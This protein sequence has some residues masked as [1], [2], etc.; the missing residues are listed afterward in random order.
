MQCQPNQTNAC[1]KVQ[2]TAVQLTRTSQHA[3]I[4]MN[5]CQQA[6]DTATGSHLQQ[7]NACRQVQ[8][9]WRIL[10]H[11]LMTCRGGK[12]L[13]RRRLLGLHTDGGGVPSRSAARSAPRLSPHLAPPHRVELLQILA[14]ATT[15]ATTINWGCCSSQLRPVVGATY[16][17]RR[18]RFQAKEVHLVMGGV[19]AL[20]TDGREF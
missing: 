10:R 20:R 8:A 11:V 3:T 18:A 15:V 12:R 2:P 4:R 5:V 7:M 1:R 14:V 6:V 19:K 13:S 17:Q 16:L 9:T